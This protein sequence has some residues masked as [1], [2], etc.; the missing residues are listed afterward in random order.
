MRKNGGE[1]F[2]VLRNFLNEKKK[3]CKK[4]NLENQS[5]GN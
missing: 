4:Y 3:R 1:K 2:D 5:T